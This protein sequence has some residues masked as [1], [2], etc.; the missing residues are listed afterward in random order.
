M[1]F[2]LGSDLLE[3]V[4]LVVVGR[5]FL[6]EYG[7]V[8]NRDSV[9]EGCSC[10]ERLIVDSCGNEHC[11]VSLRLDRLPFSWVVGGCYLSRWD[12]LL[13]EEVHLV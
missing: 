4:A 7:L 6:V 5:R 12:Y 1:M 8:G 2:F 11:D 9:G 3:V 13:W 10:G